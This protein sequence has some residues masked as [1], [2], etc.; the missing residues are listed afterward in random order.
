[1]SLSAVLKIDETGA[2]APRMKAATFNELA[3]ALRHYLVLV[4]KMRRQ[5][6][7]APGLLYRSSE[8]LVL[9][10]ARPVLGNFSAMT[11]PPMPPKAC[12]DN[13]VAVAAANPAYRYT[14]GF[15]LMDG[16]IPTHHGWLTGPDG[17]PTDPT[18]PAVY[19]AHAAGQ[20]PGKNWSG[21]AAYM[22]IALDL[23]T[24]ARWMART[25]YPN[26]LAVYEDD[27]EA[28]LRDGLEAL[29]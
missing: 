11:L 27:V 21:R 2:I 10:N 6:P 28:L 19:A 17:K 20:P 22:G 29:K 7:G 9:F 26:F 24:H 13:A 16:G 8:E 1:M 14:E 25:G 15:A 18:W 12:F 4:A 3:D 5:M 23:E